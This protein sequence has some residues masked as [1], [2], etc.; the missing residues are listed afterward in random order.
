MPVRN[1]AWIIGRTLKSLMMFC[2]LAIVADQQSNDGTRE[3]IREYG[4]RVILLDNLQEGHSTNT[5]ISLLKA[6]RD[7][8]GHNFCICVDA[9]EIMSPNILDPDVLARFTGVRRGTSVTI[10]WIQLWRSPHL[11]RDDKSIWSSRWQSV[12]FKDDRLAEFGP[13]RRPNDHNGRIPGCPSNVQMDEVKLLHFQFVLFERMLSKQRW[14]R[15]RE[16]IEIGPDRAYEINNYYCCTN[17][18]REIRFSP[19]DP[20]W[21]GQWNA[22]GINLEEFKS[23]SIYWYDIEVLRYLRRWGTSYFAPIDIWDISWE[24]KRIIAIQEGHE[25]L[26][27]T[28]IVDPRSMEQKLYHFYLRR[29]FRTPPWRDPLE[30]VAGPLRLSKRALKAMGLRRSHLERFTS[31]GTMRKG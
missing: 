31:F 19:S 21:L 11:W 9:D 28:P 23:S 12:A 16:A 3:I 4:P 14:Y 7:Y 25:G 8:D 22:V 15:A 17:D 1:E 24:K 10:P 26:P 29:F 5:R 30:I 6:A 20:E 13:I 2:D 27:D 18:E